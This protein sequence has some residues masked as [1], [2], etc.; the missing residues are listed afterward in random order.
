MHELQIGPTSKYL[1]VRVETRV[2]KLRTGRDFEPRHRYLYEYYHFATVIH[3]KMELIRAVA[4][5]SELSQE[6][7]CAHLVIVEVLVRQKALSQLGRVGPF[8]D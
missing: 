7:I 6:P 8:H 3:T 1:V 5:S 4:W 2:V